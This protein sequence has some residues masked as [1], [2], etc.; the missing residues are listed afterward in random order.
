M[1]IKISGTD[2]IDDS[3]Q[4]TNITNLKTVGGQSILG[5]GDITASGNYALRSYTT[6]GTWTK[7]TGLKAIKVTVIGG[8]AA[9]GN[10]VPGPSPFGPVTWPGGGAGGAAIE[11]I[12]ASEIPGPVAITIGEGGNAQNPAILSGNTSSFGAF[13]SATGGTTGRSS[14]AG[15]TGTGGTYNVPGEPGRIT[16]RSTYTVAVEYPIPAPIPSG[17]PSTG[18]TNVTGVSLMTG[19]GGRSLLG[20]GGSGSFTASVGTEPNPD[21]D[22][23]ISGRDGTGYGAGASGQ[24]DSGN[25]GSSGANGTSGLII[26]EE[27]Y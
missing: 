1:A 12:D 26:V 16:T 17:G 22:V 15:G 23:G 7:P 4:L 25:G 13:C 2:V 20:N 6:S 10:T 14:G 24:T 11:Y 27:F 19:D 3:R 5:T 9:S 8:G 21:P 18:A